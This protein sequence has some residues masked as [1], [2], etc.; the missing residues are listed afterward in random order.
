MPKPRFHVG[1]SGYSVK[2]WKGK[3]YPKA[4]PADAMLGYY[5]DAFDTVEINSTFRMMPKPEVLERWAATVPKSF[6]FAI[7]APQR[8]T[9]TKRLR[10]ADDAVKHLFDV[11]AVL[12]PRLGPVLFQLPPNF[13]K[14]LPRLTAFLG[15]VPPKRRVAFEF[16]HASWFDDET[17]E[18]LR[19]RKA[20]VAYSEP[21]SGPKTPPAATTD[22]GYLRLRLPAYSDAA[23]RKWVAFIRQ[24]PWREAFVYFKH[25]AT[26]TG[27]RFASRMMA[28][29]QDAGLAVDG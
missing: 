6:R 19:D 3:F 15:L 23:L 16:R 29:S 12:G 8:I 5:A 1:T 10:D 22:W 26:G 11:V 9:H 28:L 20:A 21:E 24:Q 18:A 13:K 2:E 17:L 25:E 14:D 4:L 27:P 7:K